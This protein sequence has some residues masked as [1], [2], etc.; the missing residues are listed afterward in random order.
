M[1]IAAGLVPAQMRLEDRLHSSLDSLAK[2]IKGW[3]WALYSV[4]YGVMNKLSCSVKATGKDPVQV[5]VW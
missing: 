4:E 5:T 3:D 1:N 2:L